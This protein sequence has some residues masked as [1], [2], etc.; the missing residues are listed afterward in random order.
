MC[1]LFF[2]NM[3]KLKLN[4]DTLNSF[5][6]C[7]KKAKQP[8]YSKIIDKGSEELITVLNDCVLN[9]L[10]GNINLSEEDKQKLKKHKRFLRK[11]INSKKSSTKRKILVQEGFGFLPLILPGAITLLTALIEHLT[12]K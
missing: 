10:N 9:T 6:N 5:C 2:S 7:T 1:Y 3:D 12:K 11:I 4:L 8:K